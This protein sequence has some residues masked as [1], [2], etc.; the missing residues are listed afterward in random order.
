MSKTARIITAAFV[1]LGAVEFALAAGGY[2]PLPGGGAATR[3]TVAVTADVPPA[4]GLSRAADGSAAT[5][6]P[7][8][9]AILSTGSIEPLTA[10]AWP[11]GMAGAPPAAPGL[12]S[13]AAAGAP[14]LP[15]APG[16]D[17]AA[18]PPPAWAASGVPDWVRTSEGSASFPPGP[19]PRAASAGI[20]AVTQADLPPPVRSWAA[21]RLSAGGPV[22]MAP[23]GAASAAAAQVAATA[24][25]TP[26][27]GAAVAA[28]SLPFI[29]EA[30]PPE[31]VEQIRAGLVPNVTLSDLGKALGNVQGAPALARA[32]PFTVN[33]SVT[34]AAIVGVDHGIALLVQYP[35]QAAAPASTQSLYQSMLFGV[36][37]GSMRT[38]YQENS[39][40]QYDIQG[41]ASNWVTV[42]HNRNWYADFDGLA[43]PVGLCGGGGD[44]YGC[45]P[46]SAHNT[47]ALISDAVLAA[48]PFVDFSLYAQGGVVR[49]LMIIHA[50]QGAEANGAC[51]TC[52][53][54]VAWGVSSPL[55]VDGVSISSAFVAPEYTFTTGDS[56]IGVY[57]HEFGHL[58]FGLP[59]LYDTDYSSGGV[60][61]WSLMSSGTWLN[62]GATPAHLDAWS[63]IHNGWIVPTVVAADGLKTL[64]AVETSPSVLKLWTGGS[65]GSEYFLVENRQRTGF[66]QYLPGDGLL[67]WHIDDAAFSNAVDCHPHVLLVPAD[68]GLSLPCSLPLGGGTTASPWP[69]SLNR[70]TWNGGTAPSSKRYS[71]AQTGVG[72]GS[73]SA[74]GPS[75]TANAS[76]TGATLFNDG[77]LGA[78]DIVGFPFTDGAATAAA[79]FEAGEISPCG[80]IGKT[81]WYRYTLPASPPTSTNIRTVDTIG[82]DFNTVLAVY[83][84]TGASPPGSLTLLACNDDTAELG[85][86]SRLTFTAEPGNTYYI[87]VGGA[88]GASGN[89]VFNADVGPPKGSIAGTVTDGGGTPIAGANV[90]AFGE[91]CCP[92]ATTAADGTYTI[93]GLAPG[94]YR[95]QASATTCPVSPPTGGPC[96]VY[97]WQYYNGV[98]DYY[99]A[100]LVTVAGGATTPAINFALLPGGGMSGVVTNAS[101]TPIADAQV[102]ASTQTCCGSGYATTGADGAY[103]M[104]GLAPGSY[105]VTASA[106]GY[107]AQHY[108]GA[109]D[110][111]SATPVS[112]AS[113]ITS[114]GINFALE[115][116]ATISGTVTNA[117]GTPIAGAQVYTQTQPCCR[118][119]GYATTGVDGTYTIGDL[120][121]GIYVVQARASVCPVS[122]APGGPCVVYPGQFYNGT[123]DYY[124]ATGVPLSGG[125]AAVAIN[126]ALEVGG[127]ISGTVTNASG[128]PI[129]GAQVQAYTDGCCGGGYATSAADGT[130]TI[131]GLTPGSYRVQAYA[132][133]CAVSPPSGGPCL[134][135]PTQYYNGTYD[136]LAATLVPVTGG[137]AAVGINFALEVG[138]T[139][140]G[141]VTNASGT[142]IA[143]AQVQAYTDT[144]CGGGYAT[145]AADGAYTINGLA[146]GSYRVQAWAS[147]CAFS[148][149]SGGPCLV[150]PAQ[151]YNGTYDYL[152]ATLVPVT[153]GGAAVGINFA[154]EVGGTISGKV[155]NASGTPIAGAQLSTNLSD[156][157]C[158]SGYTTSAADGTYAI[159]GLRPGSYRV[160][161]SASACAI[162][163]PPAGTCVAYP[164]QYYNGTYISGEATLVPVASAGTTPGINFGLAPGATISGRV[165]NASSTPIAGASVYA[166]GDISRYTTTAADGTYTINGLPPGSYRLRA[167]APGYAAR[168]YNGVYDF[169]AATLLTVARSGSRSGINFAL[170][171]SGTITGT[172]TNLVP[173]GLTG[174]QVRAERTVCC[175]SGYTTTSAGGA[176]TMTDLPPG[177][178]RVFADASGYAGEYFNDTYLSSAATAVPI[179]IGGTATSINFA[180]APGAHISG[181]VTDGVNP[182]AGAFVSATRDGGGGFFGASTDGAGVY[183]FNGLPPGSYRITAE[184]SG[185]GREFY[186]DRYNFAIADLVPVAVGGSVAGINLALAAI[187]PDH[188]SQPIDIPAAP[189][190]DTHATGGA[191]LEPGETAPCGAIGAT[192]WYR[193]TVPLDLPNNLALVADTSGSSFNTV[194]AVYNASHAMSPPGAFTP[195]GCNDN[196]GVSLQSRVT[197]TGVRGESYY[198]QAG[199]ASGATGSL[200]LNLTCTGDS[201]CDSVVAATDNCPSV[202]NADQKNSRRDFIDLHAYGKLFDDT[203]VL[204]SQALGDACNPDID[205]D[206][207]PNDVEAQL[208][209]GGAAHAQCPTATGPTIARMLDSDGDGF[210]D[211]AE[212]MLGTDPADP[213]SH[214]PASYA[215]GDTDHDGLPNALEVTLGTNPAVVD[216]DGD[217]LGDGVEFLR[218][219][220]SPLSLNSDG[221]I[222][223]DGRE[224]ASLNNDTNVNP[225]DLLIVAQAFG[226][227]TGPKYVLDFDVNRDGS[228]NPTDLLI[229]AK[230]FGAC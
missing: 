219:G 27:A 94:S 162:S 193:Y 122:P 138:G 102:Q 176:Y 91:T 199:G 14:I 205:G 1:A 104:T 12:P 19:P 180:L 170:A 25:P 197:F 157:C 77:A 10:P 127:T 179:V 37:P 23:A 16:Q 11:S 165:T 221:D 60:G 28:T 113:A 32:A 109:Y 84:E 198:F 214:P 167:S 36:G 67:V 225:T 224:V 149:P 143:G 115:I 125:G 33:P 184:K 230:L 212:C 147:A 78:T 208:A 45:G 30:P 92:G 229:V 69:G 164:T 175:Y 194:L 124:L 64:A 100:T 121:P 123:Y 74:S 6:A 159:N 73:I 70:T 111:N 22:A 151:Y 116:G 171:P 169:E 68:S 190:S 145:S 185:F 8:Q 52:A 207:L 13:W 97:P 75:M 38:Y 93:T 153:G 136:Y 51:R 20:G 43:N 168:Y 202:A 174:A 9:G 226:P 227:K 137:G 55:V 29:V 201:D 89:L 118:T 15:G 41:N 140:S 119:S 107:A 82:S 139:I 57:A 223:S 178:Y 99:A 128:T 217:K 186:H 76:V 90:Y 58:A 65:P 46:D 192:V 3:S 130:Y 24:T 53:W 21:A 98:Y 63:K 166:S 144:C 181:T 120:A 204:N 131:D 31:V 105:I 161:A 182:L 213:V 81:L 209:P 200:H 86:L 196:D 112:V 5:T 148:P 108:N 152:A 56:K 215:T 155:T 134:V 135:Y 141:T 110:Y 150:Y 72:L 142:P 26:P 96:V 103:T 2:N 44:D 206:G 220:S 59:D 177:A 173:A 210:T 61:P 218:Y 156:G 117:S 172:V 42:G 129:A 228:I 163:P 126:F 71:G 101:G 34:G 80:G 132:S 189:Y 203:T 188:S 17:G 216:S 195:T 49:N 18:P 146:P 35:D 106:A 83:L 154:L 88:A 114:P 160:Q 187:S 183:H 48:D 7:V 158:G 95:V 47:Q 87:Q 133:I 66:D 40:N 39:Y 85:T 50:G 222:C 211:R 54:S 62:G 79:T 4:V 191:T